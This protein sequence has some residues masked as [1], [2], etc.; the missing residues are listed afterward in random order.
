MTKTVCFTGHRPKQLN[1]YNVSDNL[2]ML[3]KLRE[4]VVD[5]IEN[6]DVTTFITGMAQGIDQWS[7]RIVNKLKEKYPHI[8]VVA[9]VPCAE[10]WKAWEYNPQAVADWH[11]I[12]EFCDEVHYVSNEPYTPWCMQVRNEW[13]VNNSDYVIAVWNGAPKGGTTNCVNYAK[14]KNAYITQLHPFKLEVNEI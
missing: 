3:L 9:A 4:V 7:A 2:E 14:K 11:E 6:K 1:G 8:K 12:I 13:M 5:H 10:H